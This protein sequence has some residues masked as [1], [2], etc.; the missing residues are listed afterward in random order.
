L[1]QSEA[2]YHGSTILHTTDLDPTPYED[3]SYYYTAEERRIRLHAVSV[4]EILMKNFP[5]FS[6]RFRGTD[7]STEIPDLIG[8]YVQQS[9]ILSSLSH[10]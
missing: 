1:L 5:F 7:W 8:G 4:C 10:D 2:V 6:N 3:R 9:S